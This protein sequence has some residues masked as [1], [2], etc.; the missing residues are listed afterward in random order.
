[1]SKSQ[2]K[3]SSSI[4]IGSFMLSI[5]IFDAKYL[6]KNWNRPRLYGMDF[7]IL[8]MNNIWQTKKFKPIWRLSSYLLLGFFLIFLVILGI[9]ISFRHFMF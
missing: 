2:S 8:K 7:S 4:P 9:W 3:L 5:Y 6:Q 1:M